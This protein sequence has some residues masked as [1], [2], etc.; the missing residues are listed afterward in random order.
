MDAYADI[1]TFSQGKHPIYN[2]KNA[3]SA[4][5]MGKNDL[6]IAATSFLLDIPLL[7]TDQDFE[8][9]NPH[10]ISVIKF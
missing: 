2:E 8:H 9:L 10:F 3:F 1:D 6:W 4:R 7:T 5:N